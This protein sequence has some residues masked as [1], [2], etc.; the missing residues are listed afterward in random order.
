M[1]TG[2]LASIFS[3]PFEVEAPAYRETAASLGVRV[4]G[5]HD[6]FDNR[7]GR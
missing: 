6:R 7:P 2:T 3:E 1:L 4:G 5:H